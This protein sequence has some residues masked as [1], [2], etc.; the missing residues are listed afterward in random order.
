MTR[1]L[2]ISLI[3]MIVVLFAVMTT[4]IGLTA[5]I[6]DSQSGSQTEYGPVLGSDDWNSWRKYFDFELNNAGTACY[7]A[8]YDGTNLGDVIFPPTDNNSIAVTELKNTIFADATKKELPVAI[9]ISG[10]VTTIAPSTFSGLP[11]LEIVVFASGSTV[12]VGA[13]A[14]AFC[15]NLKSVVIEGGRTVAF[16]TGKTAF[17]G[18]PSLE[19][20]TGINDISQYQK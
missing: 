3:I 7:I 13:Y 14:F 15:P 4:G 1:R 9:Y 11:N 6:W 20:I 19:S 17:V 10:S 18:C 16:D 5:A 12:S 8:G 2:R